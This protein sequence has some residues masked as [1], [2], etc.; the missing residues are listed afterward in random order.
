M[1]ETR[2]EP[3]AAPC[4]GGA[5]AGK[6]PESITSLTTEQ[7]SRGSSG[8]RLGR[9]SAAAATGLTSSARNHGNPGSAAL[10][11]LAALP[12]ERTRSRP[13]GTCIHPP[14]GHSEK[15]KNVVG[16]VICGIT[17]L[18]AEWLNNLCCPHG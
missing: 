17:V 16:I 12:G 11:L 2:E 6:T 1:P 18:H 7:H 9:G 10:P 14:T 15:P 13:C 4:S 3:D 5:S 8:S